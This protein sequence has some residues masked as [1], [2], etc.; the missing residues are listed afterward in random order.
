MARVQEAQRHLG[1]LQRNQ[2]GRHP[3]ADHAQHFPRGCAWVFI[4]CTDPV[5]CRPA[6]AGAQLMQ[7]DLQGRR[8]QQPGVGAVVLA[9]LIDVAD[10]VAAQTE[11]PGIHVQALSGQLARLADLRHVRCA[12]HVQ[13]VALERH[14]GLR[15]ARCGHLHQLGWPSLQ[16]GVQ[17]GFP[18]GSK[19]CGLQPGP[20]A[21]AAQQVEHGHVEGHGVCECLHAA[22]S[23]GCSSPEC[24]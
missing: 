11:V 21:Q 19:V 2:A 7:Q 13:G 23:M 9:H 16:G 14:H 8:V 12:C 6:G 5:A 24:A 1:R 20:A 18:G 10:L 15:H 4:L 22:P 17:Q 3:G